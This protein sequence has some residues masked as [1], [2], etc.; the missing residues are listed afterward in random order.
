MTDDANH[1]TERVGQLIFTYDAKRKI[2]MSVTTENAELT[3]DDAR[4]STD[5]IKKL[6]G[7]IPRPLFVDFS[8]IKSQT[9]QCRDY[10]TRDPQHLQ[11]YT[12]V[13]MLVNNAVSRVLANFFLGINK[14]PKPTQVFDDEAKAMAWLETQVR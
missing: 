8:K 10:Y 9:K 2:V 6:T 3:I 11:T 14:S 1:A 12:A 7:N 4:A 13:A 5:A